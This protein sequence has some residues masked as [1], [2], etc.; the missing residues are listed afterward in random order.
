MAV[1]RPGL[2]LIMQRFPDRKDLLR[3][4][5]LSSENFQ[6]ICKDYHICS[7]ALTYWA[8]SE[9]EKAPD[10]YNEYL[11]LMHEMES[12]IIYESSHANAR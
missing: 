1:I 7:E 4:R 6:A 2:F 5:Y 9:H 10:R 12:D 3:K 8:E 11:E